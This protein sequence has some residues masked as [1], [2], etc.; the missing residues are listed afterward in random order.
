MGVLSNQEPKKVFQFFEEICGIPHGSGNVKQISDYLVDFAKERGLKARQDERYNVIIWKDGSAGYENAE[1]LILQGHIDMVAVKEDGCAKNLETEG[2]DIMIDGDY[3]T[4]KGTSLGGDDGI[5]VAFA[6]AILDDDS[7]AH[8]PLE[9]IFTTEEEVGM[10]GADYIDVSDLKGHL[11]LN[12]DSEDEGVFTV[13]CA[14]GVSVS[15]KLP[16]IKE[17]V[18]GSRILIRI[19]G[20]AGGHS[21]IEIHK[22]RLNA[23]VAMG[24]LLHELS[25]EVPVRLIQINGGEKDNAIATWCEASLALPQEFEERAIECLEEVFEEIKEEYASVEK[26]IRLSAGVTAPFQLY[27]MSE[28][29]TAAVIAALLHMPNGVQR[30]NPEME[31]MVQT[32][33]NM[34][35][36]RTEEHTVTMKFAVRSANATEKTFLVERVRSLTEFLGGIIEMAGEYPGWEYRAESR[37]RDVMMESY[38]ELYGKE[39]VVE[40]IH[41]GLECGMF[42]AKIPDLDAVSIGPQMY[43]VHTT[44][45]KLSIESTKRTW[46]LVLHTLEKLK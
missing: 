13:S 2:L 1:P 16:F 24:R 39:P 35:I 18:T 28:E 7:I 33:L 42:A 38:R 14:G 3:V 30:M 17:E 40:G 12:M 31:G 20:F 10:I 46:D 41:A 8:P 36:L 4:A 9:A 45:E 21:G 32:S 5:A 29:R 43:H 6:L 23:N 26:N 44:E 27:A 22:G 15:S 19:D 25:R 34:G 11:F 37:L